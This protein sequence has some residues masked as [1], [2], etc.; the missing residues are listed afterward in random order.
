MRTLYPFITRKEV[1]NTKINYVNDP[2]IVNWR[3]PQLT[4]VLG[5]QTITTEDGIDITTESGDTL[6]TE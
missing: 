5:G 6:T 1:V 4:P 2:K 3:L